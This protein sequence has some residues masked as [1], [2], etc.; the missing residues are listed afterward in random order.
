MILVIDIGN[1]YCKVALMNSCQ[2]ENVHTFPHEQLIEETQKLLLSS[3][4]RHIAICSV[5]HSINLFLEHFKGQLEIIVIDN[6][7]KLPFKNLYKSDTLG[8][9]RIA[10]VA[11]AMTH[12]NKNSSA[13]VIDTGT[14]IT[15]DY[16][17]NKGAYHGGA[18]SPGLK[19]RFQAL[20]T[21]TSKLPLV[22]A[23]TKP[24]TTGKTT[25]ESIQSGVQN[26]IAMEI[27]AMIEHYF[28]RDKHLK[29]F[30][31]GGDSELLSKQLKNR[32]FADSNLTLSGIYNLYLTNK[33]I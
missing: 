15:Y 22:S 3:G 11:G 8:N 27:D 28:S 32:F 21:F 9:D 2:V 19:M 18:I 14:C 33:K 30:L 23:T 4:V 20:H 10:L 6:A 25:I 5:H 17:D 26:G 24:S 13:L 1:S 31:T 29:V 12:L 7:L 16:L